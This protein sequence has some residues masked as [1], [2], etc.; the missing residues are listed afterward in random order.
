MEPYVLVWMGG[1][2]KQDRTVLSK[3]MHSSFNGQGLLYSSSSSSPRPQSVWMMCSDVQMAG[4]DGSTLIHMHTSNCRHSRH[5]NEWTGSPPHKSTKKRLIKT[6]PQSLS[7]KITTCNGY[8]PPAPPNAAYST[9]IPQLTYM[10]R[11][12]NNKAPRNPSAPP[13]YSACSAA[14]TWTCDI[15]WHAHQAQTT[16]PHTHLQ[17]HNS[18]LLL[19]HALHALQ[20]L[21]KHTLR[22]KLS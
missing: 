22:A 11:T 8:P 2:L 6:R 4:H 10:T 21:L 12:M 3:A 13:H 9:K 7:L 17:L 18:R 20:H 16:P 19:L 5:L 15:C 1:L 14:S